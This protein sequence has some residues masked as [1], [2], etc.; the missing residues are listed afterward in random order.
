MEIEEIGGDALPNAQA[1]AGYIEL[2]DMDR[3]KNQDKGCRANGCDEAALVGIAGAVFIHRQMT[4]ILE[5]DVGD[6]IGL[7]LDGVFQFAI[8]ASTLEFKDLRGSDAIDV[9]HEYA[10]VGRNM[11]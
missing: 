3:M 7:D 1:L 5:L 11:W 4:G 9:V 8:A 2:V 10:R 6:V